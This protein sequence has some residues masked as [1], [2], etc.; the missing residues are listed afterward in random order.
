MGDRMDWA[1]VYTKL[2]CF[3]ITKLDKV[4]EHKFVTNRCSK[5]CRRAQA[6]DAAKAPACLADHQDRQVCY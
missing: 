6:A 4:S 1:L 5:P 2:T 3:Q